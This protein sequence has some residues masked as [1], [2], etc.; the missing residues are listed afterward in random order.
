MKRACALLSLLLITGALRAP[1]LAQEPSP[2]S[3]TTKRQSF[4]ADVMRRRLSLPTITAP[5]ETEEEPILR[6]ETVVL[7][8]PDPNAGLNK[9]GSYLESL[10]G[11]YETALFQ[12]QRF[13]ETGQPI[14]FER[15]NL[16]FHQDHYVVTK[17]LILYRIRNDRIDFGLYQRGYHGDA[18]PDHARA[19]RSN[20]QRREPDPGDERQYFF[21]VR[22]R[23]GKSPQGTR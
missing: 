3:P 5:V 20:P 8:L 18:S 15:G 14:E 13:R 6:I 16:F 10:S 4:V 19:Q 12:R 11:L 7:R 2:Q 22:F 1:F 23:L 21:G 17:G 9:S